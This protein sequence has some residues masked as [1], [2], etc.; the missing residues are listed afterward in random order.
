MAAGKESKR[1]TVGV[2]RH[3]IVVTDKTVQNGHTAHIHYFLQ[4]T[5]PL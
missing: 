4:F 3:K 1:Q 5:V 2:L